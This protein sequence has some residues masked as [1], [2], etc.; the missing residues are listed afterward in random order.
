MDKS[1]VISALEK[2][3]KDLDETNPRHANN[4]LEALWVRQGLNMAN[5]DLLHQLLQHKEYM[6]VLS[7]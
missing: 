6:Q 3:V 4:L 2:W 7:R 1:I 5:G